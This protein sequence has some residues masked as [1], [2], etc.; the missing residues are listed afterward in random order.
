VHQDAELF[1]ALLSLGEEL[2]HPLR[3]GR[4]AWVQV[5]R[6]A[7]DVNGTQLAAGDGAALSEEP[8]VVRR[9]PSEVLLFDLA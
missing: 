8:R 1:A 3:P 9:A 4:H 2:V 6:G 7:L 5:A